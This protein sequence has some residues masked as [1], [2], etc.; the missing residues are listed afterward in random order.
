MPRTAGASTAYSLHRYMLGKGRVYYCS[1]ATAARDLGV[2]RRTILRWRCQLEGAGK[3]KRS[4]YKV[5]SSRCRT[6]RY[7]TQGVQKDLKKTPRTLHYVQS[8]RRATSRRRHL[9]EKH[10]ERLGNGIVRGSGETTPFNAGDVLAAV[11]EMYPGPIPRSHRARLGKAAKELLEDGFEPQT[12]CAAVLQA[13]R[14]ARPGMAA[15]FALE[16]QNAKLGV[17]S[18]WSEYRV[19]LARLND[20]QRPEVQAIYRVLEGAFK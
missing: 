17:S 3:I 16:M 2:S 19:S 5:W 11:C 18:T 12:V 4:G 13:V 20:S 6:V 10:P 15:D 1:D 9:V 14:M 8:S 7:V